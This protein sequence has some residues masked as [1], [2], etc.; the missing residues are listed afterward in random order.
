[1]RGNLTI[2]EVY[3]LTR[4]SIPACA[5]EPPGTRRTARRQTVYPRVCG[6]TSRSATTCLRVFGLSPR[7]RGNRG[8]VTSPVTCGGSIPACAGEPGQNRRDCAGLT[9]Y[10]RVCGGTSL[11]CFC[12]GPYRGLSPRVRG[13]LGP[14]G[15][16]RVGIRSI[17]ACAGEPRSMRIRRETG[18]VYPRVCGGTARSLCMVMSGIGLS[19]RV[20]GN[21]TAWTGRMKL[22]GSIPACAGEPADPLAAKLIQ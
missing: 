3:N 5:G 13:N 15:K 4:R 19:P 21:P 12:G 7:V 16:G 1:M 14:K 11:R 2:G 10:P 6:G 8:G 17:P 22:T 20:R 9:V 18:T